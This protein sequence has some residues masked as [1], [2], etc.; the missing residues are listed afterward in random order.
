MSQQK[1]PTTQDKT[2]TGSQRGNLQ[3]Q[4]GNIGISAVAAALPYVAKTRISRERKA[5]DLRSDGR[6]RS[7]LAI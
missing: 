3:R 1:T 4:Y 6:K 5:G 7:V 2:D